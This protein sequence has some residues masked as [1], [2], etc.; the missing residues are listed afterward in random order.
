M[1]IPTV[2]VIVAGVLALVEE[3]RSRGQELL[4]W[5]VIFLCV[6]LLYGKLG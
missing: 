1:S 3:A 2:F 4:G 6:A 5:A